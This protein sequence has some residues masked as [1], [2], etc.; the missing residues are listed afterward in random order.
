MSSF[1]R[2]FYS[3]LALCFTVSVCIIAYYSIFKLLHAAPSKS[4]VVVDYNAILTVLLTTVTVIFTFCAIILAV[5]GI[6]GFRNL[7]R[8]AGRYAEAQALAEIAKAF[9]PTGSGTNRIEEAMQSED[10]HHRQFVERTIRAEVISLFPLI[11]ER[12]NADAARLAIDEPT[13]QGDV[14]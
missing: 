14:D 5:L 8:D 4:A 11:A 7:K 3:A 1:Y 10:G 2:I 12:I 6:F 13:D 9:D